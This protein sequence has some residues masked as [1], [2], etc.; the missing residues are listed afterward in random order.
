MYVHHN[1]IFLITHFCSGEHI[2]H[3]HGLNIYTLNTFMRKEYARV[4][5]EYHICG[6]NLHS[7]ISV[8]IRKVTGVIFVF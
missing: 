2:S 4:G 3:K 6:L 7:R 8:N 1:I 5:Q